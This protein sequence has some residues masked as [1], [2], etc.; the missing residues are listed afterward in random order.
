MEVNG[1]LVRAGKD[2]AAPIL[3]LGVGEVQDAEK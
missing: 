3:A 2:A 1:C